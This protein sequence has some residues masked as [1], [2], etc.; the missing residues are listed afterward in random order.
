[1]HEQTAGLLAVGSTEPSTVAGIGALVVDIDPEQVTSPALRRLLEQ[2]CDD[3]P[4]D[5]NPK[6]AHYNRTHN[7]HNRQFL[8]PMAPPEPSGAPDLRPLVVDIDPEQVTSPA[9]KRLLE[10]VREDSLCDSGPQGAHYDRTHHR[11]N[12]QFLLPSGG[13]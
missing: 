1:M 11:H 4:E 12:R 10:E 6:S 8:L 9:L 13:N 5:L 7:R 2:V 3:A